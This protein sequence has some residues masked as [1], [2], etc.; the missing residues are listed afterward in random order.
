MAL[1]VRSLLLSGLPHHSPA[2]AR[3]LLFF[4]CGDDLNFV[5]SE[6]EKFEA[7]CN[8]GTN[9]VAVLSDPAREYEKVDAAEQSNVGTDYLAYGKGEHIQRKLGVWIVGAG[10]IFQ[11]LH[12]AF[13][14]GECEEAA[15]MVDQIFN[16]VGA[17]SLRAKKIDKD[18]RIEISGACAHRDA[19]GRAE[20]HG[21]VDRYPVAKSAETCSIAEM[22]EDGSFG[23]LRAEVMNERL[24]REAVETIASNSRVEVALRER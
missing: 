12:I 7:A 8:R 23:K 5:C 22:R 20:A 6:A 16:L 13:A 24:V 3:D 14:S 4:L 15:L 21:G 11:R 1:V 19:T 17:E 2:V 10:A 9:I 18:T